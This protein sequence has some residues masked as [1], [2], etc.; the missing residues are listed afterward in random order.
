MIEDVLRSSKSQPVY[1][2]PYSIVRINPNGSYTLR[3]FDGSFFPR[4]IMRDAIKPI[5]TDFLTPVDEALR[6]SYIDDVIAHRTA[7]NGALEFLVQ[8]ANGDDNSWV[9]VDIIDNAK[10]LR[11]YIAR[12]HSSGSSPPTAAAAPV[13]TDPAPAHKPSRKRRSLQRKTATNAIPAVSPASTAPTAAINPAAAGR[14][15]RV[16]NSQFRDSVMY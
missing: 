11:D 12:C 8:W 15:Q 16:P 14:R 9:N 10:A 4:D 3:A 13:S 1:L 7:P 5:T 2:G 6:S